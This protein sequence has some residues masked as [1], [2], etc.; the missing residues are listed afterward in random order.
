MYLG[1]D[2]NTSYHEPGSFTAFFG[3]EIPEVDVYDFE[4][5]TWST[6]SAQLDVPIAAG[7]LVVPDGSIRYFGGETAQRLAHSGTHQSNP[8]T[9]EVTLVDSLE[10]GRHGGGAAVLGAKICFATGNGV[11]GGGPELS[12][13]EVF[14]PRR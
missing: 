14:D 9:G 6:L 4:K 5:G 8:Q 10:R 11:R 12:T 7:G 13:T 1:G 2:R 3:A